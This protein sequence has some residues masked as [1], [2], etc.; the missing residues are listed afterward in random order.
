M[1][2][3]A[4]EKLGQFYLGKTYD[5]AAG[6]TGD[7]LLYDSKDLTT[8]GVCVGMTGSGKTGLCLSLIEEAAIDNIPV[9]A[10][11]PKGDLGNLMLTFP[12]LRPEDF[13]PWVDAGDAARK[14]MDPDA[15]AAKTA[16]TW[17]KGLAD[18][19]MTPERIQ[20]FRDAAPVAIYT[21]GS[22]AGL[23]LSLLRSFSAPP[24]E[25][26]EDTEALRERIQ[27]TVSGLLGLLGIQADPLR[28]REHILI[29]NIL[30]AVWAE[31]QDLDLAGL[32]QAIQKPSFTRIGVLDLETFFPASDRLGLAMNLNNLLASPGF[33][34]WMEG[35][36]LDIQRLLFTPEGKARVS[37]LSIAHLSDG[38]RMF[39]VTMLLNEV[40][41][42]MRRQS[43]T[44]SL[45]ALLYM[46]EIFGYF[47]PS[48]EPP[49]K[50]PMLL[51]LKQARAYGLGVLIATQNPLDL[52]YK[53]LSN[54]GTWFIG[55]L[56]TERDK[57]RVLDG[58]EGA[59][60]S[61][62]QNFDRASMDAL[63]SGLGNRVFLM[64]NVHEDAPVLFQTRWCLSYLRGP[65]TRPQIQQLMDPARGAPTGR[66][67]AASTPAASAAGG[68][69]N[70]KP[71]APEGVPE[72]ILAATTPPGG[73]ARIYKPLVYAKA[74]L[75]YADSKAGVDVWTNYALL[76]PVSD[77]SPAPEWSLED[78]MEA[79]AMRTAPEADPGA[80]WFAP[81]AAASRAASYKTWSKQLETWL[82]QNLPMR[83]YTCAALGL[84][85]K[86]GESE[87]DFRGRAALA[88]REKRDIEV[89]KIRRKY[90]PKLSAMQDRM[91]RADTKIEKEKAQY[92]QQKLGSAL[93]IGTAILGA[94][95]GRKA[96]SATTIGRAGT[97]VSRV[98]RAASE[99]AD[100]QRAEED[101]LATAEKFQALQSEM[102]A[103]I[104]TLAAAYAP[105]S[106]ELGEVTILPRKGDMVVNEIGIAWKPV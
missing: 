82:Y 56:Q 5:S 21:P 27:S 8:H 22:K 19:G 68:T 85:S 83:L 48:A 36:P 30:A 3:D 62:G 12:Q 70:L 69:S 44:S 43:G 1:S 28:S 10:V 52:D 71:I 106:L 51:L 46:D 66:T 93:S 38:E 67:A 90:A 88:A 34:S 15:F 2:D 32:I 72:K 42:W 31:G 65:L 81:P 9:I 4:Y 78:T 11:D 26:A 14:G 55:R 84:S 105:E 89:E 77:D 45:R 25:L 64:N 35:E 50:R 29:S 33:A 79:A 87:G 104:E 39:F 92:G 41:A 37:I 76:A 86:A 99:R 102:E 47:P 24:P 80:A 13:R 97:A 60:S 100:V 73:S 40:V 63:L 95:L 57:L 59:A 16:E 23:Q 75:R 74:T 98:G 18:W 61:A 53:G 103:E 101:Q 20:K 91:R 94:L 54:T 49:S 6:A 58:L 17:R 7:L 96:M